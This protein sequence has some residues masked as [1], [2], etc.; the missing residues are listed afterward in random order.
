MKTAIK[1]YSSESYDS[2]WFI[3]RRVHK[4]AWWWITVVHQGWSG[5]IVFIVLVISLIHFATVVCATGVSP[6][7]YYTNILRSLTCAS[8]NLEQWCSQGDWVG[9]GEWRL[10]RAIITWAFRSIH[11]WDLFTIFYWCKDL[12]LLDNSHCC[13]KDP[14]SLTH[15]IFPT[16]VTVVLNLLLE[17]ITLRSLN[18]KANLSAHAT[19]IELV[20][21]SC[22]CRLLT[23]LWETLLRCICTLHSLEALDTRHKVVRNESWY[24]DNTN[25][26]RHNGL[27]LLN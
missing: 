13:I 27:P 2:T 23:I 6:S 1:T 26:L 22:G 19:P 8:R 14:S 10:Y 3:T 16:L 15:N 12:T 20:L 7:I 11:H 17:E 24:T 5:A 18:W 21:V 9:R 25:L 4:V